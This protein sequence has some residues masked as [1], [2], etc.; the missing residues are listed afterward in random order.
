MR[1][2]TSKL[3]S[4]VDYSFFTVYRLC[5]P[6]QDRYVGIL[7]RGL[8]RVPRGDVG[9]IPCGTKIY[10]NSTCCTRFAGSELCVPSIVLGTAE[11][12]FGI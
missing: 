2:T 12:F 11:G 6:A 7:R 9:P 4:Q 1:F 8:T 3:R 10:A 5:T